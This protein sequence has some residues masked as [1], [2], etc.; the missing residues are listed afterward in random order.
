MNGNN[1]HVKAQNRASRR[2]LKK[3]RDLHEAEYQ[4]LYVDE[5]LAEGVLPRAERERLLAEAYR[6]SASA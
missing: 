1:E 3:L 2:A 6:Q 5:A 4:A